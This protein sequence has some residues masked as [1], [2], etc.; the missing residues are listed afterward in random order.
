MNKQYNHQYQDT[1]HRMFINYSDCAR[2]D[3]KCTSY[4]AFVG[5]VAIES[6]VYNEWNFTAPEEGKYTHDRK[7]RTVKQAA[8]HLMASPFVS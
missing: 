2:K 3:F 6:D 8:F 4:L 1:M 7:G 5:S